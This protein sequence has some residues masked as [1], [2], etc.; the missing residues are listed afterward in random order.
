MST[1]NI[2]YSQKELETLVA[3][4]MSAAT[5]VPELVEAARNPAKLRSHYALPALLAEGAE[6]LAAVHEIPD[7]R[8]TT[9][10][11]VQRKTDR[12]LYLGPFWA[13]RARLA[14]AAFQVLLGN[15][16]YLN[17]MYDLMWAMCEE[18]VW[19]APQREDLTIDLRTAA[20]IMDLSE[21]CVALGDRIEDRI[22]ERVKAEIERRVFSDY[23][24]N[25][26]KKTISWHL[27]TN[28]WNGV[29]NGGVGAAFLLLE[30]DPKRL[31]RALEIVLE[32]L[33][34]FLATAFEEDGTSSE[35][36]GY[37]QYGMSNFIAFSEM[38]RIRT[39]VRS[40]CS[41]TTESVRSADTRTP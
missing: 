37:W 6:V 32:G 36:V 17:P 10:R 5:L 38:L 39:K 14:A 15:D 33:N 31:A 2:T 28:N 26:G 30:K 13:R 29:C 4:P 41:T 25:Y 20:T 11:D 35:G 34:H 24:E 9:Y 40:I 8:Y 7:L 3:K 21:I 27:G 16:E 23:L 12:Q 18:S 1:V 22:I 19:I